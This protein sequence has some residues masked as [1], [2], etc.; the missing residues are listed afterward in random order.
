M[1]TSHFY[2]ARRCKRRRARTT[3]TRR[4]TS[5]GWLNRAG[6]RAPLQLPSAVDGVVVVVA[7]AVVTSGADRAVGSVRSSRLAM[8]QRKDDVFTS[9]SPL[10]TAKPTE[11]GNQGEAEDELWP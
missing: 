6:W 9:Q 8:A 7:G 4:D 5:P 3:R 10:H 2:W 1:Q 11:K